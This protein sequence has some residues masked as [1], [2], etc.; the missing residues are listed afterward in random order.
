MTIEQNLKSYILEKYDSMTEFAQKSGVPITTLS[1]I[2]TRGINRASVNNIIK[3]CKAL[4]ISADELAQGK[5]VPNESEDEFPTDITDIVN[6]L[7]MNISEMDITLGGSDMTD[8]EKRAI[9]DALELC[10][11]FLK[12]R[13]G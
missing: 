11:E 12:R 7:K 13:R 6:L 5:I 3:I 8:E 4:D 9:I 1:S 10:V 2:I